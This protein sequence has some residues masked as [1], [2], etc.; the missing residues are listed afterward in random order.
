MTVDELEAIQERLRKAKETEDALDKAQDYIN[1]LEKERDQF[2]RLSEL[3]LERIDE[4]TGEK[5]AY[6]LEAESL[7]KSLYDANILITDLSR[8]LAKKQDKNIKWFERLLY[9][10]LIFLK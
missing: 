1:N 5:G 6:K 2:K 4:L 8:E 10:G 7:R 3:R 9:T